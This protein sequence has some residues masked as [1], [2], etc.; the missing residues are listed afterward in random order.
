MGKLIMDKLGIFLADDH[1]I[2]REGLKALV[3]AQPDMI[4]IGEADN[5]KSAWQKVRE[6]Q[7]DVAVMD[8]SMPE[9][10]GI[11]IT[12]RIKQHCPRVKVLVLTV[13]EH[14]GYLQQALKA[15]ASGYVLKRAVSEELIRAIRIVLAG[16]VYLDPALVS[17][18]VGWG[19]KKDGSRRSDLS[20]RETEVLRL[21]ALGYSNKEIG[22]KLEISVKT[23]ETYKARL[24]EKLEL[25]SRVDMV[26]YALDQG[27]LE[28]E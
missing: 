28:H 14:R 22:A 19:S 6:L 15:G 24:M 5:G 9:A 13:H 4:V 3:N 17:K 16:G 8:I 1:A 7:P 21:V 26:R 18:V 10:S 25:R 11:Q 20:D 27:W 12:E 23:V 2:I